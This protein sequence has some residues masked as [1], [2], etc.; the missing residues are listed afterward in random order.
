MDARSFEC[1]LHTDEPSIRRLIVFSDTSCPITSARH[2]PSAALSSICLQQPIRIRL[3]SLHASHSLPCHGDGGCVPFLKDQY[4]AD[5]QVIIK[6]HAFVHSDFSFSETCRRVSAL[7]AAWLCHN[8]SVI[9]WHLARV[10][11]GMT[12]GAEP[13]TLAL[14]ACNYCEIDM[15][16]LP[17]LDCLP[18]T[19]CCCIAGRE[20]RYTDPK[21]G[22]DARTTRTASTS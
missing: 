20:R 10:C 15:C 11:F 16:S 17:S 5:L 13:Y 3:V 1:T 18:V 9:C 6:R 21:R 14:G 2:H 12:A 8:V 19:C 4:C 7:R 22:A